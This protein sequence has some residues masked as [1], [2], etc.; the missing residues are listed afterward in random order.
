[1]KLLVDSVWDI[2]FEERVLQVDCV[3]GILKYIYT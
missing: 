1:M 3:M 2:T